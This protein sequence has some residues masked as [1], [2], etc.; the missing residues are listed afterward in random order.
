MIIV[1]T[2]MDITQVYVKVL[3]FWIALLIHRVI[4]IMI[5]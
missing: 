5:I 2:S 4:V 1:L 3:L